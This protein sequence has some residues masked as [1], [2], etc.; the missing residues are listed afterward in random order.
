MIPRRISKAASITSANTLLP[1]ITIPI[2]VLY[3]ET[4]YRCTR[5]EWSRR[6]MHLIS[7]SV[8]SNKNPVL[9]VQVTSRPALTLPSRNRPKKPAPIPR[10]YDKLPQQHAPNTRAPGYKGPLTK[11]SRPNRPNRPP[12]RRESTSHDDYTET[13]PNNSTINR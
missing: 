8:P 13:S 2:T 11:I 6:W 1:R 4:N 9:D 3:F 5:V 7:F 12:F 10:P